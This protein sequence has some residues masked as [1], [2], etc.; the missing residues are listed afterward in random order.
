MHGRA[1]SSERS[2]AQTWCGRDPWSVYAGMPCWRTASIIRRG[3]LAQVR[4]HEHVLGTQ[5]RF[6]Q[7]KPAGNV[8]GVAP[9]RFGLPA[10]TAGL[11][12]PALPVG[13]GV[14]QHLR[15]ARDVGFGD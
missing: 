3:L 7:A 14:L 6:D 2:P 9:A 5:G 1:G 10:E 15:L 8:D 4:V 11:G 12:F 13:N